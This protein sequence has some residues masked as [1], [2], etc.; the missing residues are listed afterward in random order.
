MSVQQWHLQSLQSR[1]QKVSGQSKQK[2]SDKCELQDQ[3]ALERLRT[4]TAFNAAVYLAARMEES[5]DIVKARLRLLIDAGQVILDA[6]KEG[7][8]RIERIEIMQLP[9]GTHRC[10]RRRVPERAEG[11]GEPELDR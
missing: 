8:E 2:C 10:T 7:G 9:K 4:Q 6:S 3:L 5:N 1:C 11:H